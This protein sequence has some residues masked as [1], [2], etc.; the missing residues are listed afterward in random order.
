[1][2]DP[3]HVIVHP[4][5][6]C[7]CGADLSNTCAQDYA[8]RQVFDLPEPRLEVTKHRCEIKDCPDC[9]ERITASF[10]VDVVA[11]VQYG[12][13]FHFFGILPLFSGT[14]IHDGLAAYW[15]Y[16][17]FHAL[18][19]AH[20]LR[21]L[22]FVHEEL[23]QS[24]AK[25]MSALLCKMNK[26]VKK[27]SLVVAHLTKAALAHW[28]RRYKKILKEGY[29]ANPEPPVRTEKRGRLKKTKP[30]NLLERL[31]KHQKSVLAFLYDFTIPF[32]NNQGEQDIR[33]IKVQQKISGTFRTLEGARRFAR[34]RSYMSTVHKHQLNVFEMITHAMAGFPF[35]PQISAE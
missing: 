13:R 30:Q 15:A 23:H 7:P 4:L 9:G 1:M 18:C 33:M 27:K 12:L 6:S 10:P 8:S 5:K 20:H 34:I 19:N 35:M 29:E 28:L 25:K 2:K 26:H 22:V 16:S 3:D 31:D 21:E 14:L 17:C 24:W 32:T 11:Q